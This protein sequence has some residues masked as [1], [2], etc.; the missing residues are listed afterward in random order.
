MY[1]IFGDVLSLCHELSCSMLKW[2]LRTSNATVHLF[3]RFAFQLLSALH[4]LIIDER[5]LFSRLPC[6]YSNGVQALRQLILVVSSECY[7]PNY[8]SQITPV[9]HGGLQCDRDKRL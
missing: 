7:I 9:P 8:V 3:S 1:E 2:E 6:R 5:L 4:R